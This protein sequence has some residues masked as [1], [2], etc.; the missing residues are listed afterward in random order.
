MNA[1]RMAVVL[2]IFSVFAPRVVWSFDND[3]MSVLQMI[4][5][6]CRHRGG[7]MPSDDLIHYAAVKGL[8][9]KEMSAMLLEFVRNGM[10]DNADNRQQRMGLFVD[11]QSLEGQPRERSFWTSFE[12]QPT[13]IGARLLFKL[14][15][16]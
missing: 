12:Q 7:P 15:F 16:E 3:D 1:I 2:L 10:E 13:K 5:L 8:S 11:W 14:A 9:D 4:F 6:S